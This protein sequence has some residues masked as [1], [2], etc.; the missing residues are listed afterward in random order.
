MFKRASAHL[1][2]SWVRAAQVLQTFEGGIEEVLKALV[3]RIAA[4]REATWKKIPAQQ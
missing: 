2:M 3:Q 4:Q 1:C